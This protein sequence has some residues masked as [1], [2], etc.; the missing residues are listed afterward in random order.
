MSVK[1]TTKTITRWRCQAPGCPRQGQPWTARKQG[2]P[3]VCPT[4]HSRR[5]DGVDRRRHRSA[6]AAEPEKITTTAY[7]CLCELPGCPGKGK[8]WTSRVIPRR[9][10]WC[11]RTSW[12]GVD[13][14]RKG[15]RQPSLPAPDPSALIADQK[16]GQG[17]VNSGQAGAKSPGQ[18]TNAVATTGGRVT[19][20]RPAGTGH[21]LGCKCTVCQMQAG[22]EAGRKLRGPRRQVQ[23]GGV[24]TLPR[25]QKVRHI[26]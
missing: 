20:A 11:R 6:P 13:R 26:E 24:V 8:S 4:C 18:Q 23:V 25:P 3:D 10:R 21:A 5:W 19:I 2:Y 22:V 15:W 9:C 14:R 7:L 12:N 16:S 1:G 17:T